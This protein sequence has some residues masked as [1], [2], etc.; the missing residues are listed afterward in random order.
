MVHLLGG[1]RLNWSCQSERCSIHM[2]SHTLPLICL[3]PTAVFPK[4]WAVLA[5]VLG[6]SISYRLSGL[7]M[8]PPPPPLVSFFTKQLFSL[9][10]FFTSKSSCISILLFLS[11]FT[12][13]ILP[14][15]RV[16]SPTNDHYRDLGHTLELLPT[17]STSSTFSQ[18]RF[19][20]GHFF[21]ILGVS[22]LLATIR[23][24]CCVVS[25]NSGLNI[26]DL[27]IYLFGSQ[28]VTILVE[29]VPGMLAAPN[30]TQGP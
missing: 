20:L 7:K 25:S 22:S 26:C 19:G 18:A 8:P 11:S 2:C 15:P 28:N 24:F 17:S 3:K 14:T 5:L 12:P 21:P 9:V 30:G 1:K 4:H 6:L 10:T 29:V 23:I 16:E 27:F 13:L